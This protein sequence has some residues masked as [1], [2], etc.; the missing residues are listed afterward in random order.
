MTTLALFAALVK[1]P[2]G[3]L[4][5]KVQV[6]YCITACYLGCSLSLLILMNSHSVPIVILYAVAYG[7]TLGGDMVL[8]ELVW[9]N[10]YGRTFLGTIRGVIMPAN[11]ISMAGGPLFGAWLRDITGSYQLPYRIFFILFLAGTFLIFLAKQ[12]IKK[13]PLHT[14]AGNTR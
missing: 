2:W 5:E 7:I 8:R 6:R 13:S 1:I 9:A 14:P 10:Y 3:M 4:A 11:L 12:P